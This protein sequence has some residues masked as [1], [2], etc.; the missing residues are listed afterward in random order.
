MAAHAFLGPIPYRQAQRMR[1][2]D[3]PASTPVH[4]LYQRTYSLG[5]KS[6]SIRHTTAPG[7]SRRQP[8]I[9]HDSV[10]TRKTLFPSGLMVWCQH[11]TAPRRAAPRRPSTPRTTR[12]ASPTPSAATWAAREEPCASRCGEQGPSL[13]LARSDSLD[14]AVGWQTLFCPGIKL[15]LPFLSHVRHVLRRCLIR[16]AQHAAV[17]TDTKKALLEMSAPSKPSPKTM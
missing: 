17:L 2:F 13:T 1:L 4:L 14:K 12:R 5:T 3:A 11:P 16:R 7:V 9:P 6:N 15:R 10:Q 8:A